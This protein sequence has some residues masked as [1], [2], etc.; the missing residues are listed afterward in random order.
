[1]YILGI[2]AFFHD[3]AAVLLKN[4]R[5][6]CAFEEERFSRVKHDNRFPTQAISACL[7]YANITI[8]DIERIA[9]FEKPLRKFERQLETYAK[10]YP[11]SM[12]VFADSIS[13]WSSGK[14]TIE[15]TIRT[16]LAFVGEV[17]FFPHHMSHVATAF[18]PSPFRE[19]AILIVDGVGEYDTT[20]LWRGHSESVDHIS[21]IHFP[22]SLGLLYSA[23]TSFLGFRVNN[24]EYKVMGLAALGSPR[25][26]KE[27][28]SLICIHSDNSFSLKQ[29]FFAYEYSY[30]MWSNRFENLFGKPRTKNDRIEQ[31]HMDIAQSL[32]YITEEVYIGL[33]NQLYRETSLPNVCVGGGVALNSVA[34]GKILSNTPFSKVYIFGASGDSGTALGAALL[35]YKNTNENFSRQRIN[36]L[37][38]GFS[39]PNTE[40]KKELAK[41]GCA[42]EKLSDTNLIEET[43]ALIQNG[44]VVGWFQGRMEF[45][46][47][48]LGYR[49]ILANPSIKNMKDVVNKIKGRESFRPLAASV[50]EDNVQNIFID[51]QESPF[52][53]TCLVSKTKYK[54]KLCAVIHSDGTTRV[55]T[56]RTKNNLFYKLIKRFWE[57]TGVPA[58]LNTSFNISDEPIVENPKQ[59]IH[60]FIKSDIDYLVIGNYLCRKK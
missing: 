50:S 54:N 6:L 35:A 19:A 42:H 11:H 33:L 8:K 12:R 5:I 29:S 16:T 23:V 4:G 38:L 37:T 49:S 18:Y 46:P 39:Y 45:G 55:H 20:S 13:E 52:M 40:I 30:C 43:S 32:Q 47:R 3:S 21:S 17:S 10:T 59:A 26:I 34:T 14:L 1:M 15:H 53:N 9:Y 2:S 28:H 57:R 41:S 51:A 44:S 27:L 24:D 25:Y 48:A 56:V 36:D 58:I 7:N 22:H 60:S 31:R